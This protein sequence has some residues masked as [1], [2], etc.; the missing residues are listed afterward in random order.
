MDGADVTSGGEVIQ[1]Q[2]RAADLSETL[3]PL[4]KMLRQFGT[5]AEVSQRH[6]G[7][8]RKK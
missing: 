1:E 6:F 3:R 4:H 5:G 2:E 8:G 7:T